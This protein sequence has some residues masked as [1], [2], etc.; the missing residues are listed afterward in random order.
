LVTGLSAWLTAE[1]PVTSAEAAATCK[2]V[3]SLLAQAYESAGIAEGSHELITL[4]AAQ[5]FVAGTSSDLKPA[6]EAMER[7]AER[8]QAEGK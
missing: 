5:D 2:A 8:G 4:Q 1:K 6:L 7:L 3:G